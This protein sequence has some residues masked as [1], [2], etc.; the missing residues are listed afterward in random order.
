M[1]N[2]QV[3]KALLNSPSS[4][5]I[6]QQLSA[7]LLLWLEALT[8]TPLASAAAAVRSEIPSLVTALLGEQGHR[9]ST[10]AAAAA[11]GR[12]SGPAAADA[13]SSIASDDWL[14]LLV[15]SAAQAEESDEQE[16]AGWAESEGEE[17]ALGRNQ[18]D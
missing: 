14:P 3:L 1:L 9:A 7:W 6:Q 8:T 5:S 15:K 18:V 11:N 17:A 13:G 12:S 2:T 16:A 10:R 4:Q